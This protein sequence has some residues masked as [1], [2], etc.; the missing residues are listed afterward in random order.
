MPRSLRFETNYPGHYDYDGS[1]WMST[2]TAGNIF[3]DGS[4]TLVYDPAR[5]RYISY[6]EKNQR[7][8]FEQEK[9]AE[10]QKA[11]NAQSECTTNPYLSGDV[12][13]EIPE[14]K[15]ES[16]TEMKLKNLIAYYYSRR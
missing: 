14:P 13:K 7:Y 4:D 10:L 11:L 16:K 3:A 12:E 1:N 6:K 15:K 2:G 8:I 5:D 9:L